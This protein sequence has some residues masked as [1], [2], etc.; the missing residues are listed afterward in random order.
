[1]A[2]TIESFVSKLQQDGVQA[3][4]KE[5]ER[6]R[7]EARDEAERILADA[8]KQA[9]DI[10]ADAEKEA[11]SIVS[12][13]RTDLRLA[14]RDT[15]LQLRDGLSR[16]LRGVL[17][18]HVQQTLDD[19]DFLG[20]TLHEVIVSYVRCAVEQGEESEILVNVKPEMK[21]KLVDW[22]LTEIAERH[23]HADRLSLDLKGTLKQAGFEYRVEGGTYQVTV[24]SVVEMLQQM[25]GPTL[26]D[27]IDRA[28]QEGQDPTAEDSETDRDT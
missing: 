23:G 11:E 7:Q 17:S 8:R 14:A 22:A 5:A 20:K 3:G 4:Q 12:R 18:Y 9:E 27:Q 25:V 26:R 10:V 6:I 21:G 24:D 1:M 15:I 2:E 19:A 16:V 28:V 13:G